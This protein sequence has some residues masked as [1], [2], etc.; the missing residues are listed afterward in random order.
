MLE[1]DFEGLYTVAKDPLVWQQ[2]PEPLRYQKENFRKYFDSGLASRGGLIV[3]S[4]Q[5]GDMIGS[6]R[7]YD[8]SGVKR[9]V[10][11]GYTFLAR[12]YWGGSWNRELKHLMLS[13]A[14]QFVETV[15]FHVDSENFRSQKAL[16]KIGARWI[17]QIERPNSQG[18]LRKAFTYG[19]Q[20][21]EFSGLV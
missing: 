7:Y 3:E 14:F 21:F 2:H 9:E 1:S 19:L 17:N 16:E 12:E 11:I 15:L 13:H 4:S 18:E 10:C 6:S 8:F 20:K 5:T